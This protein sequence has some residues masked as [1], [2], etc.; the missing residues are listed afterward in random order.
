VTSQLTIR[1][2]TRVLSVPFIRRA[3]GPL[4]VLSQRG[5]HATYRTL[6]VGELP[7]TAGLSIVLFPDWT[8]P[9][10]VP[11]GPGR[12]L[13]DL[14]RRE[15]LEDGNVTACI[16]ACAGVLVP[17]VELVDLVRPYARGPVRVVPS[18]V[19]A[20]WFYSVRY[21]PDAEEKR[22]RSLVVLGEESDWGS[23]VAALQQLLA[24]H[25]SRKVLTP[26]LTLAQRLG[27]RSL[28]L[29]EESATYPL[30]ARAASLAYLPGDDTTRDLIAAYELVL[31]GVPLVL[32]PG[33]A[34]R[35]G[36]S[37]AATTPE[38]ARM[39]L[40]GLLAD[41]AKRT[42]LGRRCAEAARSMTA[43]QQADSWLRG[44]AMAAGLRS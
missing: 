16:A 37:L 41:D 34:P 20:D 18:S 43:V 7:E 11:S 1:A 9:E 28:Y 21:T 19:H 15:L 42:A 23:S 36:L 31:L 4:A 27:H 22:F 44:V 25:S 35:T 26:D 13:Y 40:A 39:L 32:G 8:E 2:Y 5:V 38:R 24:A 14:S 6:P 10:L 3:A 30:F 33:L 29:A 17:T 12:V